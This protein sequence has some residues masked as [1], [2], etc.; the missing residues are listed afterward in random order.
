M[1][2]FIN[3]QKKDI[4]DVLVLSYSAIVSL[5]KGPGK[6]GLLFTVTYINADQHTRTAIGDVDTYGHASTPN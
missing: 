4:G 5:A 2:I 6:T 3:G 1:K